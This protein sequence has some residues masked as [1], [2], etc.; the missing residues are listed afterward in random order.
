MPS[1]GV[2]PEKAKLIFQ[3]LIARGGVLEGLTRLVVVS[4]PALLHQFDAVLDLS[5]SVCVCG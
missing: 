2:D 3:R 4:D 1:P 5:V